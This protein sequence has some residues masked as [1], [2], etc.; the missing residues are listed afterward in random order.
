MR[1][2]MCKDIQTS[3]MSHDEISLI[4]LIP[5]LGFTVGIWQ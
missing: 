3:V 4:A 2:R 1:W 5:E